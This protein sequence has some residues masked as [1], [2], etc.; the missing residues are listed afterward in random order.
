[1]VS[2]SDRQRD[3]VRLHSDLGVMLSGTKQQTTETTT[4]GVFESKGVHAAVVNN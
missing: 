4:A 2:A 1:L 3:S